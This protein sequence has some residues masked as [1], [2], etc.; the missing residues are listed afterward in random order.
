MIDALQVIAPSPGIG[1]VMV[2]TLNYAKPVANASVF[3]DWNKLRTL[4]GSDSTGFRTMAG[5]ANHLGEGGPPAGT[6]ETFW[7]ITL[8]MDRSLLDFIVRTFFAQ[9]ATIAD[10]EEVLQVMAIQPITKGA[11]RA[12]QKNGGNVLGLEL[13]NG[14]YFV[15]N[16]NTA[17]TKVED[18]P[19]FFGAIS[20]IV[21]AVKNEAKRRTLDN[22]FVYL[23]YAS[24]HQDPIASYGPTNKKRLIDIAAKYDPA[25]VF[26]YLQPGGFKLVLGAPKSGYL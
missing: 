16:F 22:N 15:L 12:M 9:V 20:N 10:V 21:K 11:M 5:M 8:K 6:F 23:N 24:E 17:W 1:K 18:E 14:P 2:S 26:Q 3:D 13:E 19:K 7:G 25:Q 4:N